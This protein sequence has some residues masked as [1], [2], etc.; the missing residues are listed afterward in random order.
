MIFF[1]TVTFMIFDIM[2]NKKEQDVCIDTYCIR[3]CM[4]NLSTATSPENSESLS[5]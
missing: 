4:R 2:L 3:L 5:N 1:L